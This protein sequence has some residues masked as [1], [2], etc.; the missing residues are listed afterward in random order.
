MQI[1]ARAK[2]AVQ[3][4]ANHIVKRSPDTDLLVLLLHHRSAIGSKEIS[5][6]MGKEDKHSDLTRYIPVHATFDRLEK[7]EVNILMSVCCL[8]GCDTVSSFWGMKK[9]HSG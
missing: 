2:A 9:Q 1:I 4:G 3:G 6:P 8:T 7:K 5:L